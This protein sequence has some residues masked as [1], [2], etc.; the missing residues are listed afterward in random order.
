MKITAIIVNYYTVN[1]LP[2][3]LR[4]LQNENEINKIII[5]DNGDKAVLK[6][7]VKDFTKVHLLTFEKNMGFGAAVN[8]AAKKYKADYYLLINPDTLPENGFLEKLIS[9]AE[10]S[11]ALIAGP[12]FYW[13]DKKTFRLPPAMGNSMWIQNGLELSQ[14]SIADA[15]LFSFDW[16]LRQERFWNATEPFSESFLSG[17]C[18]LIKNNRSFFSDGKI[19]DERFFLYYEDTDLCMKALL[20]NKTVICV[21]EAEVVHYWDQSPSEDKGKFMDESHEKFFEKY[22]GSNHRNFLGF[23]N[24]KGTESQLIDLGEFSASPIFQTKITNVKEICYFE[25]GVNPFFVP[26]AQTEICS[27]SY[28]IPNSIWDNFR[29]GIYFSRLRTH[30]NKTQTTW[31]WKKL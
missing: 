20:Q 4:V 6:K 8:R 25:I 26:F 12:R 18:L 10:K 23:T 19:F 13:D 30:F 9:G 17:A 1:F 27:D 3:L 5:A 22:Y 21:P 15:K 11:N 29:P 31:K 24:Q 2:P 14:Q 16:A 7:T 28:E